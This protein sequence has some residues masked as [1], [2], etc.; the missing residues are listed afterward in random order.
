MN[1]MQVDHQVGKKFAKSKKKPKTATASKTLG[2]HNEEEGGNNNNG[3]LGANNGHC[4]SSTTCCSG[5]ESINDQLGQETSTNGGDTSS[6]SPKEPNSDS[7]ARARRG[8]A[9]DPQSLYA[10]VRNGS[11]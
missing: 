8:S 5:D 4:S 1:P 6:L 2:D 7:K 3:N 11:L 10:R 9:T